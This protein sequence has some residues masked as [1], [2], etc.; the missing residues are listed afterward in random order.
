MH[1]PHD[2]LFRETWS[3]LENVRSFLKHYLPADVLKLM[4]L[5]S[6]EISKDSFVEKELA[7]YFS[8][9]LYKVTLSGSPG[10]VYVLFEHKSYY[11]KYVHLQLLEYMVKIWR[12]FLKQQKKEKKKA[13][14]PIVL[15][16]LICHGDQ[17]W[18]KK[19][20]RFS[21]LLSGPVDDLSA[22]IPD[23]NFVLYDLSTFSDDDIKGT[24]MAR[25]VMLLFKHVFDSDLLEKLPGI[26]SLMGDLMA[27]E[28]GLQYLETVLRYLFSTVDDV[29]TETLKEIVEQALSDRE[30]DN[31]MTLAEKLRME[32]RLEGEIK[33]EIKG[34]IQAI[35]LGISLRFPDKLPAIMTKINKIN[36]S[37]LL[38]KIIDAIKIAKSDT[39]I[40]VFLN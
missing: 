7:D 13:A 3:N 30:G 15:P 24:V 11:D 23:F 2:K 37:A 35:E 32:G 8:D 12:L 29:S 28:T 1:N 34:L 21:S 5:Q 26:L 10:Y 33:G 25:V 39:D 20:V 36:D 4:D 31:I 17:K 18:P 14:L 38:K 27:K 40:M 16:L 22:Y 6:L 19:R 9:M